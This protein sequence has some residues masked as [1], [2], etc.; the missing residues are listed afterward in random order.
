MIGKCKTKDFT[1]KLA[2]EL[3][4]A[5]N[6]ELHIPIGKAYE[7]CILEFVIVN[8]LSDSY[9]PDIKDFVKRSLGEDIHSTTFRK[10]LKLNTTGAVSK[11][12]EF[13][14]SKSVEK[15]RATDIDK[16]IP[17]LLKKF[18]VLEASQLFP[19]TLGSLMFSI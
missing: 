8:G 11:L 19:G 6:A 7:E 1:K 10:F 16:S 15:I 5:S 17:D 2:I 9:I 3:P 14:E 18:A 4:D 13:F 12:N